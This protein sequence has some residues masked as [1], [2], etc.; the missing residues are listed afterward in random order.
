VPRRQR[1]SP[2]CGAGWESRGPTGYLS[3]SGGTSSR[4][5][6]RRSQPAH[7]AAAS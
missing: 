5:N 1:P 4:S 7:S 6:A 3:R 2:S